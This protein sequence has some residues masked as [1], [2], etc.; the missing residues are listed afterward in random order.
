M[1]QIKKIEI[2]NTEI[3]EGYGT[4]E[5]AYIVSKTFDEPVVKITKVLDDGNTNAR[6]SISHAKIIKLINE[7]ESFG[8]ERDGIENIL[9]IETSEYSI[10]V[11]FK[12]E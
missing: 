7:C 3:I 8:I 1:A 2:G 6:T 11:F 9:N 10:K 12:G 5:E 4:C